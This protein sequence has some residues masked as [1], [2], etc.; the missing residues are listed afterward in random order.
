[1]TISR[2]V[3]IDGRVTDYPLLVQALGPDTDWF[4]ISPQEDA[5]VRMADVLTDY[6][7][8]ASVHV[9]SHGSAGSLSLGATLLDATDL[10]D[11]ALQWADVGAAL[12]PD[13][14]LLFY[15][16]SVGAGPLGQAFVDTLASLT[17]ADVAASADTTGLDGNW[18]LE[19]TSGVV[20]SPTLAISAYPYSLDTITGTAGND[21]LVGTAG[22]DTLTGRAGNDTRT[23][24]LVVLV[25][26]AG[27]ASDAF[28]ARRSLRID[29]DGLW[30]D[31]AACAGG[32]VSGNVLRLRG[33][34][35]V[36]YA[37]LAT[38]RVYCQ[39]A[40]ALRATDLSAPEDAGIAAL[41]EPGQVITASRF[42]FL[43]D[44][45][46]FA[47]G[48]EAFQWIVYDFGRFTIAALHGPVVRGA[49]GFD[50]LLPVS[51]ET[52]W[53]GWNGVPSGYSLLDGESVC[54]MRYASFD[55]AWFFNGAFAD[56]WQGQLCR[57]QS[58]E[59]PRRL[60][61]AEPG[62]SGRG[63]LSVR[64]S[65][66]FRVEATDAVDGSLLHAMDFLGAGYTLL[67]AETLPDADGNGVAELALLAR[68]DA[69]GRAIVQVRNLRGRPLGRN[70]VF[71]AAMRPKDL[72]VTE[73]AGGSGI[74]EFAVLGRRATDGRGVVE[75]RSAAGTSPAR[76]LVLRAGLLPA[77]L[78]AVPDLD[79]AGTPGVAVL[80]RRA[81]DGRGVVLLRDAAGAGAWRS[82]A[83]APGRSPR[84]IV[85]IPGADGSP[86]RDVAVLST[87]VLAPR[88]L[89]EILDVQGVA[90]RRTL[91]FNPGLHALGIAAVPDSDANGA[92]EIALLGE[93][94]ADR[95]S[96]FETRD[97]SGSG[98]RAYRALEWDVYTE[99]KALAAFDDANGDGI[100]EIAVLAHDGPYHLL[101]V[102]GAY[103]GAGWFFR[104]FPVPP[105]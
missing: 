94:D 82:V 9:V 96:V 56:V 98:S 3:F 93:R 15:G 26:L 51:E 2:V 62:G 28:A 59:P 61:L 81:Q 31:A 6:S 53:V 25:L 72:A 105:P 68:R 47:V 44:D 84:A 11:Y 100:A 23:S 43:S 18:A 73:G 83:L 1:M 12:A 36:G 37:P 14:D 80:A 101:G 102:D 30:G 66:P 63:L 13:G 74:A 67:D 45:D 38:A 42:T 10:A 76:T 33:H 58:S 34:H 65:G 75:F 5:A 71:S 90:P 89:V 29:F 21:S 20:Q 70:V 79:G 69:D 16:C 86:V 22:A 91:G 24:C 87:T 97:A 8:L 60:L 57:D 88:N 39:Y 103:P 46:P 92:P 104:I 52:T 78:A 99:A 49:D 27:L 7:G 77:G 50:Q 4:L 48:R 17:G 95:A 85:P 55:S 19:T 40:P 54:F 35:L 64:G 41:F 32:Q